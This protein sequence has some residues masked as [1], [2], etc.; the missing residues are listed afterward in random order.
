MCIFFSD[1]TDRKSKVCSKHFPVSNQD[2]PTMFL[3]KM[4]SHHIPAAYHQ[5]LLC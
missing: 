3:F 2:F 1:T 5:G 4:N